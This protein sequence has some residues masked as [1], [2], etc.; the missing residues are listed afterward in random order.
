MSRTWI[1]VA[2]LWAAGGVAVAQQS[3]SFKLEESTLN[4]GGHPSGGTVM[5]SAGFR[6]SL[7]AVGDAALATV[8]A[9]ARSTRMPASAP[10]IRLRDRSET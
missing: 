8:S 7:D 10:P 1:L 3:T 2:L 6:M 5:T 9:A 4:A